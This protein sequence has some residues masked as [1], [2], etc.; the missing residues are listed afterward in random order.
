SQK[1]DKW[2]RNAL[3]SS[4]LL[5]KPEVESLFSDKQYSIDD[6]SI[7]HE[8]L[9]SSKLEGAAKP[10]N[11]RTKSDRFKDKNF[12]RVYKLGERVFYE[13]GSCYTCHRD[14]GEGIVRIY[15]PLV[16]SEWV[17]GDPDRLIKLT[18]H[19]I[20][21]KIRVR[22]EIF[23]TTQGV[24]PMTAIGNF[25]TD[26]EIAGAL[27][28]VRNSWGNDAPI[29]SSEDVERVRK[30]TNGRLKFYSPEE[31]VEEH[32]FP[33]GS[34]PPMIASSHNEELE[35]ELQAEPLNKL[36]KEAIQ[37]GDSVRGAKV[38]YGK[39]TA[40]AN[41]HD[42][43]E[44]YQMAPALTA[45]RKET[46]PEFLIESILRPSESILKGFQSVNVL[47]VDGVSLSGFLVEETDDEI[48]ISIASDGG[49]NRVIPIDDVEEV[50]EIKQSTMPTGLASLCGDRQGFLDLAKFVIEINQGGPKTLKQLKRKAKIK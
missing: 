47:T 26:A 15:P 22:G 1:T 44:G 24:P 12:A 27:T 50:F 35:T 23:E 39:K 36:V 5:L 3:N 2:I 19:G 7:D 4:M 13:E 48:A 10:K 25:F 32:P 21:G 37:D 34:R 18:L 49:K 6:L 38:F 45:A 9:L 31:L 40:C 46:T 33:E 43:Q 11:Y 42:I 30:E 29:V 41:C 28:Y 14:H 17:T 20:W 8:L 16:G